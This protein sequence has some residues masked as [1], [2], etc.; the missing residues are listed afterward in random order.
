MNETCRLLKAHRS[1]RKFTGQTVPDAVVEEVL[2]CGQA[3]ATSSNLQAVTVIRVRDAARRE[4]L[5]ALA[6]GQDYVASAGAFLVFCADLNRARLACESQGGTFC[7]DMTE[8]FILATVD[9]ALAAQNCVVAAESLGL[10]VCYIGALRNAPQAV[11]DLLDLPRLVYPV[12]GL[13]VG[14]P[15]QD[16]EVKPRLP[17][18]AVL[19]EEVYP[20]AGMMAGIRTY[21]EEIRAYYRRRTG[22]TKDSCWS[23]EMKALVGREARP[24]MRGFLAGRGF[25]MK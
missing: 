23:L 15:A 4:Q 18:G 21:D 19:G 3:A 13:C 1:I 10:G 16:P 7:E 14:T 11:A 12:F 20:A 2:R 22:G 8:H 24:H 17:L 5:A 9:V 6:G 25:G